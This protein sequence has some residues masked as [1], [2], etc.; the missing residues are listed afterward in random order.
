MSKS[1]NIHLE[2]S[3]RAAKEE[4]ITLIQYDPSTGEAWCISPDGTVEPYNMVPDQ[5]DWAASAAMTDE[6]I[7]AAI[8]M[9]DEGLVGCA[10]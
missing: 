9:T 6:E 4:N 1:K 7:D 10:L 3:I 5:S 2:G 8:A